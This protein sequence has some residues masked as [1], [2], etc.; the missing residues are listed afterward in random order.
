LERELRAR[1]KGNL[2]GDE[3]WD[4]SKKWDAQSRIECNPKCDVSVPNNS[5]ES[6]TMS[7]RFWAKSRNARIVRVL[8]SYFKN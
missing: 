8:L 6:P 4:F 3:N 1:E 5:M 7:M 2:S